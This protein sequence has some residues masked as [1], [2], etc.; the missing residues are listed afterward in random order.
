[1]NALRIPLLFL[2]LCIISNLH[3]QD[4]TRIQTFTYDDITKRRGWFEFPEGN[5]TYRKVMM[6]YNLKCDAATTQDNLPCGEWDYTTYT[7]IYSYKNVGTPYFLTGS[8]HQ[9]SIQFTPVPQFDYQQSYQYFPSFSFILSET[10]HIIGSGATTSEGPLSDIAL[11]N[12][13]QYLYKVSE[14]TA[15]GLSAGPIQRLGMDVVSFEGSGIE[16]LRVAMKNTSADVLD[17]SNVDSDGFT[18]VY[19]QNT[20]LTVNGE[21]ILDLYEAF[22]W[23][24]TS[25]ILVEF[26]C[27]KP[28]ADSGGAL[29]TATET[30]ENLGLLRDTQERYLDFEGDRFVEVPADVFSDVDQEVTLSFWAY[31]DEATMPFNSWVLEGVDAENRR[32]LNVHLPWS[33][34]RVYWDAG[35]EATNSYDRID[36]EVDPS[37]FAGRWTHWAFVKDAGTGDMAIYMDGDLLHSGTGLTRSMS[38][39]ER[40][41]LGGR[42]DQLFTGNWD[43][44]IDEFQVWSKALT[45]AEIEDHMRY[46]VELDH[47]QIN[48]LELAYGFNGTDATAYDYSPNGRHGILIGQPNR[49]TTAGEEI[50]LNIRQISVRPDLNFITGVYVSELDSNLVEMPIPH[51]PITLVES[52]PFID[53]SLS[54]VQYTYLDTTVVYDNEPSITYAPDGS[55]FSSTPAT[56]LNTIHNAFKQERHQL[57]NYV[58]PYG[59]G[60]DLGPNGFT[61]KYEVTDYASIFE[62]WVEIAAGNQ[63]ELIDLEFEFIHGTPPRDIVEFETIWLGDYNHA[64][65][66]DDL[67]MPAVDRTLNPLATEFTIRT[68]TTGHWFGGVLNCA[69][70]C[71]KNFN[72]SI[73]GIE[74]FEW[75]NWKECADNPVINQGGTWIYDRAGWCPGT[76]ADSYNHDITPFVTP[77][78]T[79][80]IDFGMQPYVTNGGEGNYRNTVQLIQYGPKNFQ[81]DAEISD[82]ISPNTWEF[83]NRYNPICS[84]P[85]IEIKN[86]GGTT[87]TAVDIE[88][89]VSG[90]EVATYSWS[91]A[92]E[93]NET[94]RVFLPMQDQSFWNGDGESIFYV[95]VVNPN[96]QSDEHTAND[97][98]T[99]EFEFPVILTDPFY[100]FFKTNNVPQENEYTLWDEMGNVVI[101]K[102]GLEANTIYRDTLY[103]G[104]GC[105]TLRLEDFGHDGLN[106]FANN[107]GNGSFLLR[108]VGGGVIEN[109]EKDFGSFHNY[110]FVMDN[111]VGISENMD[112]ELITILPNPSEGIFTLNIDSYIASVLNL[113]VLD[114]RGSI[115]FEMENKDLPLH[116]NQQIDLS[117][118]S[119]GIYFARI[120]IDGR[121]V[122]RKLIKE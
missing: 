14:L 21:L 115:V 28:T 72:L 91:G 20:P 81:L 99:A 116:M 13:A 18:E 67:V 63:Q 114:S 17:S 105:Y 27:T 42:G 56:G 52:L 86:L 9:D 43:G 47:P 122:T 54:G 101:H 44:G 5:D 25:N 7:D 57:Q 92:L 78:G 109:F 75:L 113:Q 60:L 6:N 38:G 79:H 4:T 26:S 117:N 45:E 73:D 19:L 11:N 40:F 103:L 120:L 77:G 95:Q 110:Q 76:F 3:A 96:G 36:V 51:T 85:E 59:I 87:L 90:G 80:S 119:D 65:I 102:S 50:F 98:M 89:W 53:Q 84:S 10:D 2:T 74:Q 64:Q 106:F 107:D 15:A 1:M 41:K 111:A 71:P 118:L 100:I 70:F 31:G 35:N 66:A 39:I 16:F 30:N 97:Q 121:Q 108:T 37:D 83:H 49:V 82:I 34:G 69:E 46:S 8:T 62:G 48:S 68:R 33:N 24:G 32:V 55:V 93:F 23:D 12:R 94:E 58:T 88:Y 29:V 61:W 22:E 104:D 112:D